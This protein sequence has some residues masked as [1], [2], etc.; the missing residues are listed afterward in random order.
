M[1]F[2]LTLPYDWPDVKGEDIRYVINQGEVEDTRENALPI[3]AA[4][5]LNLALKFPLIL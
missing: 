2:A 1:G 5:P 4:P 3:Y